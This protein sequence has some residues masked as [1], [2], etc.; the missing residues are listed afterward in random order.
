[1]ESC[2]GTSVTFV[3]QALAKK[4]KKENEKEEQGGDTQA[5]TDGDKRKL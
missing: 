1:M 2:S 3:L 5:E 4:K